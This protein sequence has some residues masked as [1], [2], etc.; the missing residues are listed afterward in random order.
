[1][2]LATV[3]KSRAKADSKATKTPGVA[4]LM[5][6]G[7]TVKVRA[8]LG[9]KR[10]LAKCAEAAVA[11]PLRTR[12][13]LAIPK[14]DIA[15]SVLRNLNTVVINLDRRPD[16]MDG[17]AARLASKCPGLK[18]SRLSATD[19][20]ATPISEAEVATSW[21]TARNVEFQKMRSIRKGWNDL[22]TYQVRT[23]PL[24]PGE[25]GCC[26]SHVKAW[27]HCLESAGPLLVLED[28]AAPTAEFPE[29]L[30][31]ALATLPSDAGILYLGYSQAAP[32]RREL[33]AEL[34]EAEYVWTTVAY[35][36]WPACARLLLS[37]LPV[38]EPVDNWMAGLCAEG[39]VKSYC[40]RPK[41]VLQAD[42]WNVNSDVS[43]SD[44]HYWGPCSDIQ[45]TDADPL[46]MSQLPAAYSV[47]AA[48]LGDAAT[49]SEDSDDEL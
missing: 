16:R 38:N 4:A 15:K 21:H 35:I 30:A 39:Q 43:H 49:D 19:G 10:S 8:A 2:T 11:R 14:V 37:R 23:L 9:Q 44:E 42:A 24:S 20:K 3:R 45:H 33:S 17:C 46:G 36:I 29:L 18:F 27:R 41:I 5:T 32:W 22:D 6:E 48:L 28:D 47:G 40:V 12:C 7:R 31:K 34:V 1:M 13:C 26:S 25:R